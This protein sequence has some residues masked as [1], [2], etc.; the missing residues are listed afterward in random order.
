M[1]EEKYKWAPKAVFALDNGGDPNLR[2]IDT[3][4]QKRDFYKSGSSNF[5]AALSIL[6]TESKTSSQAMTSQELFNAFSARIYAALRDGISLPLDIVSVHGH[7]VE[8]WTDDPSE[9]RSFQNSLWAVGLPHDPQEAREFADVVKKDDKIDAA[10]K[11]KGGI[12]L[13]SAN[14]AMMIKRDGKGVVLPLNQ[15]DF[16]QLSNIEG[17][18]PVI[19]SIKPASQTP[20]FSQLQASP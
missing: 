12:D 16:A 11:A 19:L 3:E 2:E 6:P 18:D 8:S 15:Q 13:N 7:V 5:Y 20:L 1:I 17:L 9:V 14:L 10:M 4:G